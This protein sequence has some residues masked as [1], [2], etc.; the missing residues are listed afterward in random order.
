[1]ARRWDPARLLIIGTFRPSE[2]LASG[3]P[4]H[5]V[6][7]E[8]LGHKQCQELTLEGLSETM[9]E[10][11]FARRFPLRTF[12]TRLARRFHQQT[13]GNPLFLVNL[14][15]DLVAHGILTDGERG[16][17]VQGE[18][19]AVFRQ[20]PESSRQLITAQMT[21]LSP[22]RQQTLAAASVAGAL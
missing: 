4:L 19:D 21:R 22:A 5:T 2:L 7:R 10:A 13:G 9:V 1:V 6:R 18:M 11:Y 14:V 20:V 3:H 12:S 17:M 16:W 8:L 15:D